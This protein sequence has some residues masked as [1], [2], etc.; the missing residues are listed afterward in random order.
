MTFI[1]EF[2][3]KFLFEWYQFRRLKLKP[4][5]IDTKTVLQI[6]HQRWW[7]VGAQSYIAGT[8]AFRPKRGNRGGRCAMCLLVVVFSTTSRFVGGSVVVAFLD[9]PPGPRHPPSSS[10]QTTT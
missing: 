2:S 4:C 6:S 7:G 8:G 10:F 3:L 1:F 9:H 5:Q